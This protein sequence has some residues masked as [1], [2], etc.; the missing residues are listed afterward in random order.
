MPS[1]RP[2]EQKR[3]RIDPS[4]TAAAASSSKA[5]LVFRK[6]AKRAKTDGA[7]DAGGS[8]G[9]S[10]APV[11]VQSKQQGQQKQAPNI[12]APKSQ[13][14]PSGGPQR[15]L[16]SAIK[17]RSSAE[18]PKPPAKATS[19]PA[20]NGHA[21]GRA[22][23]KSHKTNTNRPS[24]RAEASAKPAVGISTT[25][26]IQPP[27]ALP[28]FRIITGSYERLLYGLQVT[29]GSA[30]TAS[31]QDS[32]SLTLTPMF[33]FPAHP[34]SIKCLAT[35]GSSSKWL[36]TAGSDELI[37]IWDLRRKKEVGSLS[38]AQTLGQPA[39]VNFPL[40][41]HLLLTT[42]G[43]VLLYRTRDWTLLH[44]FKGHTGRVNFVSTH[45]SAKL[46]LSGGQDGVLRA[47]DLTR[48]KSLGGTKIGM[49][50]GGEMEQLRWFGGGDFFALL[51]RTVVR[52]FRR[53]MAEVARI[54]KGTVTA[55]RLNDVAVWDI[56]KDQGVLFVARE[57]KR[58]GAYRFDRK[59]FDA[60]DERQS[61]EGDGDDDEDEEDEDEEAART[62]QE[63]GWLQGHKARV[64][65]ISL[66]P[67]LVQDGSEVL[68]A[69]TI[70]SDGLVRIFD[71]RSFVQKDAQHD[72]ASPAV[73]QSCAEFDTKGA[74]LTCLS[75]VGG[76][77]SIDG[78]NA[79]DDDDDVD[80]D[81][82]ENDGGSR[83]R[84][85]PSDSEYESDFTD[86]EADAQEDEET[87]LKRLEDML[88]QAQ[89]EGIDL[90]DLVTM[91]GDEDDEGEGEGEG[92]DEDVDVA[93][94]DDVEESENEV[95]TADQDSD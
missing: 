53:N 94:A 90:D 48:G 34:A 64:K 72:T 83:K 25:T 10:K 74:R 66:Q 37:K 59:V 15:P 38:G 45:P 13:S 92:E 57:D 52:I 47:W 12:R 54:G 50:T 67:L 22:A 41:S 16:K 28:S 77:G 68:T 9:K 60:L 69:T 43:G 19:S 17:K 49:E 14:R 91:M 6:G 62:L 63:I 88:R 39:S 58:V 23:A 8:H 84:G 31:A 20:Q 40:P 7:S 18:S 35:A 95:E 42:Q 76:D 36:V 85:A 71:V 56:S 27:A 93:D 51:G 1:S 46:A 70:S 89:K 44:T 61:K 24:K 2:S 82:D 55:T 79:L 29:Q 21:A 32:L 11:Q 26:W 30:N 33:Q 87:E 81:Q 75:V 4:A 5:P 73:I 80:D 3:A 65:S 78:Q 86:G